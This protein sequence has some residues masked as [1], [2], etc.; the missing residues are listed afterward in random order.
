MTDRHCRAL[1][2]Y[3]DYW[4]HFICIGHVILLTT[5][6]VGTVIKPQVI[7]ENASID[8]LCTTQ[9]VSGEAGIHATLPQSLSP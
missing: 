9:L 7:D 8:L 3:Q 6:E 1:T 2:V 4:E 5:G